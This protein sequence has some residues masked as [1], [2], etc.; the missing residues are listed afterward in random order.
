MEAS[1]SLCEK[2]KGSVTALLHQSQLA[3]C[4]HQTVDAAMHVGQAVGCLAHLF[5]V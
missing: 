4:R 2:R 5:Q 3:E 1:D